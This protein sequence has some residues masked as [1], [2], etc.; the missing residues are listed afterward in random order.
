MHPIIAHFNAFGSEIYIYSYTLFVILGLVTGTF[1]FLKTAR[2]L[3]L[4][5]KI[6]GI[7][8]A[9]LVASAVI[10]ARLLFVI[11]H[12]ERFPSI[13]DV[14]DPGKSGMAI[15]GGLLLM[16]TSA[17][18]YSRYKSIRLA[19]IM[20]SMTMAVAAGI[21]VIRI[22]CFLNGCCYGKLTASVLG[23]S[24]PSGS[25]PY[26][27]QVTEGLVRMMQ[28]A[29]PVY[30]TQLFEMAAVIIIG[31]IAFYVLRSGL[32]PGSACAVFFALYSAFRVFNAYIRVEGLI[33]YYPYIY[34][35]VIITAVIYLIY[36][37]FLRRTAH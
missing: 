26:R 3:G 17:F 5:Q 30:P 21:P 20:D 4:P 31:L 32:K 13:Q 23:V 28:P 9:V 34:L 37:N 8:A 36:I 16:L 6:P 14:F 11:Q 1:V 10:G 12:P 24:F 22:G 25:L 18:V 19:H 35:T 7:L 29:L 2:R 27:Q 15:F 33:W